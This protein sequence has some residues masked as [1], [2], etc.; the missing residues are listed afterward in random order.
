MDRELEDFRQGVREF[1]EAEIA[2]RAAD[3]DRVNEFPSELW[4]KLG[5]L[6]LHGM[7]VSREYGG[8][9][10]GYLAH[11]VAMEEI[12]RASGSIGLSY[13][14]HSNIC[15]DNL[16]RFGSRMQRERYV[17]RLCTGELVGA[18]AM[19]E[20]G[21]GS[22]VVGSMSCRAERKDGYWLANGTKKWITNGPHAD[23]LIVYMRTADV[24]LGSKSVTAFL[25]EKGGRYHVELA[26]EDSGPYDED[27]ADSGV[28]PIDRGALLF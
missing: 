5:D 12:S 18:L 10:R 9:E 24:T 16:F 17:P 15:L 4:R 2:P 25:V 6:G 20:P 7:T 28:W 8:G 3:I 13:A 14:A 26:G 21:A 23:V 22:D 11:T 1:A 19:S 27:L